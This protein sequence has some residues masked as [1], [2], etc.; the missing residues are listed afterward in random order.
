MPLDERIPLAKRGE[1]LPTVLDRGEALSMIDN[2]VNI[3]HKVLLMLLYYGGLRLS[4]ARSL[5]WEDIDLSRRTISIRHGKGDKDRTIFLHRRLSE[6]LDLLGRR[7]EGLVLVSASTGRMYSPRGIQMIVSDISKKAGIAKRVTPHTFR[8]SFATHLLEAGAD[9]R[10]IQEL[11]GHRNLRTTQI[12]THIAD[13]ELT[14]L[15]DLL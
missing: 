12:Y 4:E 10:H 2:A 6:A 13:G 9:I 7:A 1:R 3:K 8:H 15:S 14:R 5:R 11:L